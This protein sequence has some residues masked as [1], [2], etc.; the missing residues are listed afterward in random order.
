MA[1]NRDVLY[2][3]ILEDCPFTEIT[4]IAP[5]DY[6]DAIEYYE[7]KLV[8]YPVSFPDEHATCHFALGKLKWNEFVEKGTHKG[9]D[10]TATAT[11]LE[12][13]LFH[14]FS[15]LSRFTRDRQPE[16][17][18]V[19]NIMITQA[20]RERYYLIVAKTSVLMKQ[21]GVTKASGMKKATDQVFEALATMQGLRLRCNVEYAIASM[22]AGILY[23]LQ[24]EDETDGTKIG[25]LRDEALIQFENAQTQFEAFTRNQQ[26]YQQQDKDNSS[27]GGGGAASGPTHTPTF[28][29]HVRQL[30]QG[31]TRSHMEG[32]IAY[33]TGCVYCVTGMV[34][35]QRQAYYYF[36]QSVRSGQL[37]NH[38]VEWG[39]AHFRMS[40][41][42]L[43]CPQL[44]DEG[45]ESSSSSASM[46][47]A[48]E[49]NRRP[50][51]AIM[52]RLPPPSFF[53]SF[54][55]NAN[56]GDTRPLILDTPSL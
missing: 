56:L 52:H 55:V 45:V 20:L 46:S 5:S 6:D 30:L 31:K 38:L 22:E 16:T 51:S 3:T 7:D 53:P 54:A 4:S 48:M 23:L 13:I 17:Y 36:S 34:E 2:L 35:D 37:P 12:K 10:R 29:S 8:D 33:L 15:A 25:T 40:K 18:A 47:M 19:L 9:V 39:D 26:K 24:L 32:L 43:S 1:N 14:Y 28:P 44:L 21:K 27:S 49:N 11:A 41:L 50:Q 42:I